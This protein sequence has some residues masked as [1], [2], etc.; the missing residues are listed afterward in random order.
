MRRDVLSVLISVAVAGAYTPAVSAASEPQLNF[1]IYAP[2]AATAK[3]AAPAAD[4]GAAAN[5]SSGDEPMSSAPAAEGVPSAAA[6]INPPLQTETPEAAAPAPDATAPAATAPAAT[7]AF[8]TSAPAASTDAAT[9]PAS[10]ATTDAAGTTPAA[11]TPDSTAAT[12]AT[13]TTSDAAAPA[14]ADTTAA[15]ST[16][17]ADTTATTTTTTTSDAAAPAADG[18]D[19]DKTASKVLQGYVRVVPSGTKIP[20]IMDT[21][22]DSDTSQEGD[23]FEARTS[24]DL[25]IDG[26]IAVPAG[27]VIKGRIAQ[28]AAP[29]HLM[30]GGSVA[31]KFDTVTTPDNR[32]IPLVANL[33]AHGGVVHAK[34]GGKDYLIDTGTLLAPVA[35]GLAIGVIAGNAN[36]SSNG[37]STTSNKL[38]PAGGALIGAGVGVAIGVAILL[39]KKGKRIDVR[40]GDEL[41]IELAEDLRMPM[42]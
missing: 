2:D 40:P 37:T 28:L 35:A 38:G 9:A 10:S 30:R 16:P 1:K 21:A 14:G 12:P 11:S 41:K 4:S 25:D 33:V 24:E 17:A 7:S 6:P 5:Q 29:K 13:S 22:V 18:A 23:E 36:N 3:P 15:A 27:S 42:M 19:K 8:D 32:Q 31:L 34:R 39:A 20:I 26:Q